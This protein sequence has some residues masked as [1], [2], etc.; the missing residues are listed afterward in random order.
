VN[1][2]ETES[3][4]MGLFRKKDERHAADMH[5]RDDDL[6]NTPQKST[7]KKVFPVMAAGSGLFSDGYL[8]NVSQ[9]QGLIIFLY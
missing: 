3:M 9:F 2:A 5:E 8:N 4:K 6:A 1:K 7:L